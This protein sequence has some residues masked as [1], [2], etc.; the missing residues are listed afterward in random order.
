[1]CCRA[2]KDGERKKRPPP[3][4]RRRHSSMLVGRIGAAHDLR[5]IRRTCERTAHS[6]D[7][8]GVLPLGM[9][10][11]HSSSDEELVC[12]GPARAPA[13]IERKAQE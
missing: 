9:R 8:Q 1:V 5:T 12:S 3:Y 13:A 7:F 6:G 4:F 10:S 2:W 11:A